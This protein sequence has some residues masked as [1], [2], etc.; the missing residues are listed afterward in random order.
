MAGIQM[1]WHSSHTPKN[2]LK[3]K[4]PFLL[5]CLLL[6]YCSIYAQNDSVTLNLRNFTMRG[7]TIFGFDYNTIGFDFNYKFEKDDT[8]R[9]TIVHHRYNFPRLTNEYFFVREPEKNPF[10]LWEIRKSW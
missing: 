6:T 9:L 10:I 7:D 3:V 4:V 8:L 2:E 1:R 5:N